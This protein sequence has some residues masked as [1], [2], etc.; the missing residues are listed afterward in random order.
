VR[1]AVAEQQVATDE[2]LL[3][4]V[5]LRFGRGLSAVREVAQTEALLSQARASLQPLRIDLEGQMNRLDVLLGV[6]PG[7]SAPE[8][9]TPRDIPAVAERVSQ[10]RAARGAAPPAGCHRR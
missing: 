8:L 3:D 1:I 9:K 5:R 2:H 7:T 4:L 10:R 6:Q